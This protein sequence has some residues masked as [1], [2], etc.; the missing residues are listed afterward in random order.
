MVRNTHTG[1]TNVDPSILEAAKGM[2]STKAQILF[3]IKLPLA[4]PVIMS[5]WR[6]WHNYFTHAICRNPDYHG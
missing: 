5:H 6:K 3:K 1:V 4:M 2:G